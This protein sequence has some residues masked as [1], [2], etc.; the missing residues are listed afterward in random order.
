MNQEYQI[1]KVKELFLS[2]KKKN[3]SYSLRSFARD[4]KIDPSS[5]SQCL[6]RKRKFT[7]N[8]IMDLSTK[9]GLNL[10]EKEKF[11]FRYNVQDNSQK[12]ELALLLKEEKHFKII[13][14]WEYFAVLSVIDII[15]PSCSDK[16]FICEK[17]NLTTEKVEE[18]LSDLKEA[19]LIAFDENHQKIYKTSAHIETSDNVQSEAL[20][21][22]YIEGFEL[23]E[24]KIQEVPID[25]RDYSQT[26]LTISSHQIKEAKQ[27]IEKFRK[28]FFNKYEK[29][30]GD[31]VYQLNIQLFPLTINIP[32]DLPKD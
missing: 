14:H 4:L 31:Q 28:K 13:A 8:Q 12:L 17:L 9:L 30:K 19:G 27:D 3:S 7:D 20:R 23:A 22:S 32:S 1:E 2:K 21:I 24:R 18:V 6:R 25:Q 16:N 5:L 29:I 15:P 11:L 26:T 10:I